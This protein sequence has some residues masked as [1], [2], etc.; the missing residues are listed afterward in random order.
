MLTTP[1]ANWTQL[2]E[3]WKQVSPK[4]LFIQGTVNAE[5]CTALK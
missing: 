3:M 1:V 2:H 4:P 5:K